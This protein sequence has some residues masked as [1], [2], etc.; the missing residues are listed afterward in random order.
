MRATNADLKTQAEV[1]LAP[2]LA[3][4]GGVTYD[5]LVSGGPTDRLDVRTADGLSATAGAACF[6]LSLEYCDDPETG[7][8][9]VP[10]LEGSFG[11]LAPPTIVSF[12]ADDPD[13]FDDVYG[14]GDTL[15]LTLDMSTD[16]RT[17]PRAASGERS[18]VDELFSF[19]VLSK[20]A[21]KKNKNW[22]DLS[23]IPRVWNHLNEFINN[24]A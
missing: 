3:Q 4:A 14:P 19:F 24:T 5:E 23:S 6:A 22:K 10:V 18:F 20:K 12:V 15:T 16:A 7:A 21:Q 13:D 1:V 11:S 2:F 8:R 17:P 9:P